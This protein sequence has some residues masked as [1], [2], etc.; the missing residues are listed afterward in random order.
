MKLKKILAMGMMAVTAFSTLALTGCGNGASSDT[1]YTMWIYQGADAS[2]YTDYA[3]NPVNQYLTS[4]TWGEE[5]K[6]V[7][8]EYW[9]P[10]AGTAADNYSTM[11]GSGD[12]PDI[13]DCSISDSQIIMYQQGIIVDLTDYIKDNMPNYLAYLEAHPELH[14][15]AVDDVDGEEKYLKI[16]GLS[17]DYAYTYAGYSYRRD[18]IVKYGTDPSTGAAFTGGYTDDSDP[19]S[20]Q[21]NVKF[22]SWYDEAKKAKYLEINPDWDGSDPVYISDWEWMFEIF[23]KAYADLGIDD[24]YCISIYYQGVEWTGGLSSCFGGGNFNFYED[25]DGK[26][27]YGAVTDNARAYLQCVNNWYEKGWLDQDF[28]ERTSDMFYSIDDTAVRQ[29]KVGMWYGTQAQL[30][31]RMD[32][33]DE[34]T[35]GIYV[36][37]CALPINDVY[38]G[39]AQKYQEPDCLINATGITGVS[40]AITSLAEEEG[41]DIPTLLSMIDYLYSEEG[42]RIASVGLNAE[43]AEEAG[44]TFYE[45]QGIPDGA[46]TTTED[47]RYTWVEAVRSDSGGLK[48]AAT[49]EKFPHLAL[50]SSIDEGYADTYEHYMDLW[51]Q[52]DSSAQI[53]GTPIT[54]NM[55]EEDSSAADDIRNKMLDYIAINTVNFV[56]GK[57]DIDSDKDWGDWCKMLQKYNYQ[58]AIDIYQPYADKYEIATRP[59]N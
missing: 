42:A 15:Y 55:T 22:P 56:K 1:S 17:E 28:N 6:K 16:I 10:P 40:Y 37:G 53:Q 26:I 27:Q 2:Y 54:N 13:L 3:E 18:W 50:V 30:G 29:G 4:K 44:V 34:Y 58:K 9:V 20:W 19:D 47:G 38:G 48:T 31:G 39:D 32:A 57:K 11:M 43:E 5:D 33:D 35:D 52:F 21:D 45:D 23:E 25:K 59:K 41:K 7:S 51:I 14:D 36:A 8:I 46:Y 49:F 24:S 12:Y